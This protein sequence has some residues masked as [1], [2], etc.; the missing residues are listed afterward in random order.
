MLI[1]WTACYS[2]TLGC[3]TRNTRIT[4]SVLEW[5]CFSWESTLSHTIP[6][7]IVFSFTK[8]FNYYLSRQVAFASH[9]FIDLV[10]HA[11][12]IVQNVHQNV[13]KKLSCNL[14]KPDASKVIIIKWWQSRFTQMCQDLKMAKRAE[15]RWSIPPPPPFPRQYATA[16]NQTV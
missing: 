1:Y 2:C 16:F 8:Y 4:H 3:L 7:T 13:W 12:Q 10:L 9:C 15:P 11:F 14:V 6:I 5:R